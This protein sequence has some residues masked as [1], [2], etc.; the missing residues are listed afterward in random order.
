MR[1]QQVERKSDLQRVQFDD[2]LIDL[3]MRFEKIETKEE[4]N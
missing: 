1:S 2:E 3:F 4:L